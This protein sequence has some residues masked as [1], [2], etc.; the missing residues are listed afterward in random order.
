MHALP[1]LSLSCHQHTRQKTTTPKF[2]HFSDAGNCKKKNNSCKGRNWVNF[3]EHSPHHISTKTIEKKA[4]SE[5][6]VVNVSVLCAL[7]R[8]RVCSFLV[9]YG[10]CVLSREKTLHRNARNSSGEVYD[11]ATSSVINKKC[12]NRM[13]I[14]F[15]NYLWKVLAPRIY[16]REKNYR[17]YFA[18]NLHHKFFTRDIFVW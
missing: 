11:A 15:C 14:C 12:L 17:F 9:F 18:R 10:K 3:S 6:V 5:N 13:L 16:W 7:L 8:D 4:R 1:S 2:F